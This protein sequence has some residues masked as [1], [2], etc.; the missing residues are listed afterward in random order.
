MAGRI[1]LAILNPSDLD[2]ALREEVGS[3]LKRSGAGETWHYLQ[4]RAAHDYGYYLWWFG[5]PESA[6][7]TEVSAR[8]CLGERES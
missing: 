7:K 5:G 4:A 3:W 2:E 8:A 1:G 6:V